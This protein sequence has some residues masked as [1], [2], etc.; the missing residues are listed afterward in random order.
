MLQTIF[1]Y[2]Y[3]YGFRRYG[4]GN[5]FYF[6]WTFMLIIAG[7]I[8]SILVQV[9]MR[10]TFSKYKNVK[11]SQNYSGA[12]V[13]SMILKANNIHNVR[14]GRVSGDLTDHYDPSSKTL[15]LSDSVHSSTS[16]A[17]VS[18]AAH[19]CGHAIQDALAY[20]PLRMRA[21]LVPG[22]N[23]VS[24]ICWPMFII[25]LIF[26]I[27]PLLYVGIIMFCAVLVFQLVTL[28][29]EFDASSRAL[30]NLTA[31]GVRLQSEIKD[32]KKML[33]AAALTYVAAVA[34]TLL[35]LLRLLAIA[36]GSRRN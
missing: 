28:P 24:K 16:L 11:S 3:G 20:G 30:K 2:G 22:V 34:V 35:Q 5:S 12:Q 26:S 23:L 6:D 7:M 36:G 32:S 18:V 27:R 33:N 17:A 15:N 29:V 31:Q 9:Y 4:Y 21:S 10:G 25:G 14:I 8:I 1:Q 19:E 13:A